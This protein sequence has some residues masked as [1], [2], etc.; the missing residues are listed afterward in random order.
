MYSLVAMFSFEE[1]LEF[2]FGAF[3]FFITYLGLRI[4]ILGEIDFLGDGSVL[5]T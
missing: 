1:F 3:L 4:Q 5:T 2:A